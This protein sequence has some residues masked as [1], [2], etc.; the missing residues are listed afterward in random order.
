MVKKSGKTERKQKSKATHPEEHKSRNHKLPNFLQITKRA[1]LVVWDNKNLF[2]G[3]T[4]VYGLLNVLLAQGLANGNDVSS[5][6]QTLNQVFTGNFGSI[7]TGL[8]VFVVLIGSAGNTTSQTAGAYQ[9]FLAIIGSLAVI[10]ALRQVISGKYPR[11]RDS[12]YRGMYPL[13]PFILVLCVIALQ[14]IPLVIGSTI[15]SLVINNGI[16]V[17]IIEKL[18]WALIY[19]GL[20]VA[21]FYMLSASLFAIYI[22]SLPDMTPIKALLSAKELVK[23]RR[24]VV[25]RKVLCL[26]IILVVVAAIIMLPIIIVLTPLAQYVFF[27]LTMF[28]LIA[29]HAYLYTLYRELI[30]E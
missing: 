16:A 4:L 30:N 19:A 3:I 18:A 15:Y 7:A 13:I 8:S 10:W 26:P 23:G 14:L 1:S 9:T 25:L 17:T 20:A 5:L 12:F 6:K 22:V 24:W 27:V 29:I 2:I 21:T 11:V 28:S